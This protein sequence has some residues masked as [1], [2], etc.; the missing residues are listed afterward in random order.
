M[1][2]AIALAGMAALR[3]GAGLVTLALPNVCLDTAA[4]L[5]PSYMTVPLPSDD[6]GRIAVAAKDT[7]A[8][9]S[10][11]AN[12][13]ACGPG[14]GRSDELRA[15]AGWMYESLDKP[16]VFDADA[17]NALAVRPDGLAGK[18]GPRIL[19]PH[20]GEFE[21]L[22]GCRLSTRS[23]QV[24]RAVEMAA[25]YG[26]VIVLKGHRS[27]TTDGRRAARNETGNP[28]MATGG[29]G[30]VLTGVITALVCQAMPPFEAAQLG[31]Y[32]HG[33]AGDLAAEQ[34]GQTALIASDLLRF[35]PP[36]FRRL[37]RPA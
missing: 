5:E 18:G 1:S 10:E 9:R 19:T 36:A 11:T 14:F 26:V 22:C 33:L 29:S 31:V 35:L 17:L 21:R 32:I 4:A 28:G 24:S 27:L 6:F 7:I 12:C 8:E 2:G 25:E 16:I 34:L 15:L 23:E 13:L 30:D 20:A 3:S 37:E